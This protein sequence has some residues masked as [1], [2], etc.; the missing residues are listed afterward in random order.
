[1]LFWDFFRKY[2]FSGRSG[3]VV[4][5]I[6]WLTVVGMAVSV[7]ALIIVISVMTALNQSIRER[8]LAVEPHLTL[9]IAG[10]TSGSLLD[11]HPVTAK[12]RQNPGFQVHVFETQD[13]IL[14]TAD[15]HFRGAVAEGMSQESLNYILQEIRRVENHSK[16]P[17]MAQTYTFPD[18][19]LHGGEV[20]IGARQEKRFP[21]ARASS[22]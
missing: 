4:K 14:R 2:L 22:R 11:A 3:A 8:T 13:V 7:S 18:E 15:G 21:P 6:S 16:N 9:E 10:V 20:L 17:A 12:L 5:K 1:M 19:A